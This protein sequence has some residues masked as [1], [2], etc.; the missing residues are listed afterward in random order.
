MSK[1]LQNDEAVLG[2]AASVTSRAC[3]LIGDGWVKGQMRTMADG[4][5]VSFCI[6]GAVELA[7]EEVF[8]I[9]DKRQVQVQKDVEDVAVAFICDEAFNQRGTAM[10]FANGIPAA[11]YNDSS[12]R[13]HEEVVGVLGRAAGR[14]WDLTVERESTSYVPSKWAEVDTESEQAQQYLYASLN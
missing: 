14:L 5:P 13:K 12:E 4:S 7:M 10:N 9:Y 6:H 2:L 3:E 8:G 11:G 1:K